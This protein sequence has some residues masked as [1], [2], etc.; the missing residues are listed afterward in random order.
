[1]FCPS[2][3]VVSKHWTNGF[4]GGVH[5]T[6]YP[7]ARA[8]TESEGFCW[9]TARSRLL[10][11]LSRVSSWGCLGF[12]DLFKIQNYH[13]TSSGNTRNP[14]IHLGWLNPQKALPLMWFAL[15]A[16]LPQSSRWW[17]MWLLDALSTVLRWETLR[18]LEEGTVATFKLTPSEYFFSKNP[19]A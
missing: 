11:K 9:H 17:P 12:K 10:W 13:P 16:A 14:A 19:P 15:S 1:M 7:V 3:V 6:P 5:P 8:G 18:D 4:V 2:T